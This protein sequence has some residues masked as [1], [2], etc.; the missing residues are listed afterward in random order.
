MPAIGAEMA[1]WQTKF[2]AEDD[3][4]LSMLGREYGSGV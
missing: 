1:E 2:K 3:N 4:F